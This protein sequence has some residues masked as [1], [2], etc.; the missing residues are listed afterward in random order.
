[1]ICK[2]INDILTF[3]KNET[4]FR[5]CPSNWVDKRRIVSGISELGVMPAKLTTGLKPIEKELFFVYCNLI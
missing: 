3:N 4:K 5:H 2:N 1:M